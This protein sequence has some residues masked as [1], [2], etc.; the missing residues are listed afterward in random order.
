M[1]FSDNRKDLVDE[2]RAANNKLEALWNISS[3]IKS[4]SKTVCDYI[5]SKIVQITESKYGFYGFINEDESVM[6]IFSWSGEAMKNCSMVDK[7]TDFKISE[8]GVWAEAVRQRKPLILNDY[9]AG[10]PSK[11]GYPQGHVEL[12][13][14]MVVP[15]ISEE[16]IVSLAAVANKDFDYDETDL[17]QLNAFMSNVQMLI[18]RQKNEEKIKALLAEKE[19]LLK[20]VHHRI[21]NNMDTV[22][23]I[24]SLQ[25][26]TLKEPSAIAALND[27]QSRVASMMILY[28]KLYRSDNFKE[29]SFKEYITPLVDEIIN[30]FPNA[31]IVTTEKNID[32][33]I[34][35]S[36]KMSSIGIIINEVL[37]NIMKYAFKGRDGGVITVTAAKNDDRAIIAIQDNGIGIPESIN[38]T[39]SNGF[40]LQLVNLMAKQ[41]SATIKIERNN[42]TKFILEFNL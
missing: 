24:L 29:L 3:I 30:N 25:I 38:I 26:D 34:I 35:N 40:G 1:S 27:A 2:L 16:K 36:K 32:D 8:S 5:L 21:K 6:T 17:K 14:L 9:S 20:E 23:G 10:C 39:N 22:A 28:D 12:I 4:D 41:L 11:K 18:D 42:G 31:G 7:P 37:T 15:V 19:L 13:N 33:L